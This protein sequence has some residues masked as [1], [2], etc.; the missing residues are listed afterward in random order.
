[1]KRRFSSHMTLI[2]LTLALFFL[3]LAMVTII[4]LYTTAYELSNEAD[5]LTRA[6][7]MARDCAALIEGGADPISEL[8]NNGYHAADNTAVYIL[9]SDGLTVSVTLEGEPTGVGYL[10][11]GSIRVAH[12]NEHLIEWP[13]MRYINKEVIHP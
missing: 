10:Y 4:G 13:V 12:G 11:T 7:Q 5:C 8:A 3:M 2:E 1:M 9:D 6:V